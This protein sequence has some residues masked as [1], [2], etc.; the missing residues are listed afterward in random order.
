VIEFGLAEVNKGAP[1]GGQFSEECGGL[2]Q[3]AAAVDVAVRPDRCALGGVAQMAQDVPGGEAPEDLAVL[4]VGDRVEPLVQP[5]LEQEQE[6][7]HGREHAAAD[8]EIAD[9]DHGSPRGERGQSFVCEGNVAVS[10]GAQDRWDV[11][12]V[13]PD[14]A[15][16]RARHR[17]ELVPQ[18]HQLRSNMSGSVVECL[19]EPVGQHASAAGIALLEPAFLTAAVATEVRRQAGTGAGPGSSRRDDAERYAEQRSSL[20]PGME[21]VQGQPAEARYPLPQPHGQ[22]GPERDELLALAEGLRATTW[23]LPRPTR[24]L[25]RLRILHRIAREATAITSYSP[26][27]VPPHLQS[28]EHIRSLASAQGGKEASDHADWIDDRVTAQAELISKPPTM[29]FF[30]DESALTERTP[31]AGLSDQLQHMVKLGF[32]PEVSIQLLPGDAANRSYPSFTLLTFT[33]HR[34]LVYLEVFD[35]VLFLE[36]EDNIGTYREVVNSLTQRA[37]TPGE[38]QGWLL[39]RV[40]KPDSAPHTSAL[41]LFQEP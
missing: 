30:V 3:L 16:A 18:R 28:P 9:V 11:W 36:D 1:A 38:T 35:H 12:L 25:T 15:A 26:G 19:V 17:A 21:T 6:P 23:L 14:D 33:N 24:P 5:L 34:P 20:G 31:G 2:A 40:G 13:Q 37:M 4:Q 27:K 7:V 22:I 8:Q 10:Q 39:D 29:Q 32:W 41:V